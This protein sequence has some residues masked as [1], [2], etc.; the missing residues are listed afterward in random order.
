[1]RQLRT[2]TWVFENIIVVSSNNNMWRVVPKAVCQTCLIVY[3]TYLVQEIR[4]HSHA[5]KILLN[6]FCDRKET[7]LGMKSGNIV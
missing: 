6:K 5:L 3:M 4:I 1:M 2:I 7:F